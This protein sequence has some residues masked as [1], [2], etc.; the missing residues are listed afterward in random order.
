[1]ELVERDDALQSLR[2]VVAQAR[3]GHGRTVLVHGETG[4]GKSSLLK[5]ALRNPMQATSWRLLW[6]G[7]E[8]LF[9]GSVEFQ[10]G[11][12]A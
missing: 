4:I 8:A 9:S 6:G 1:M 12:R 3:L 2:E 5:V 10:V 7:C 11:C